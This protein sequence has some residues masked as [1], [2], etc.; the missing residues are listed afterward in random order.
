MERR[1]FQLVKCSIRSRA[2]DDFLGI[3]AFFNEEFLFLKQINV[4]L[5]YRRDS[6]LGNSTEGMGIA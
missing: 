5:R 4:W 1:G 3:R 2:K 6:V